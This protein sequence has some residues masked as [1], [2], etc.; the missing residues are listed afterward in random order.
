MA[1]LLLGLVGALGAPS[2]SAGAGDRAVIAWGVNDAM[3]RP[4]SGLTDVVAIAAGSDHSLA[5]KGDGTVVAFGTDYYGQTVVPAGLSGVTAIAAG[6][7]HSSA[8]KSDG[9]VVGWGY[10][11]DGENTPPSGLSDVTAISDGGYH[12][13]ARR[14]DGTVVSW[15]M[16]A[17]GE[18]QP[19]GG[20]SGVTAVAAGTHHSL[21][22]RSDGTVV[23]WGYDAYGQTDVPAG[24]SGVVAIGAGIFHSLALKSDG[25]VVAWGSNGYGQT[26]VPTGLTGVTAIT[27]GG[28]NGLALTADGA[29]VGWGRNAFGESTQPATLTE[30][31][32]ISAGLNHSLALGHHPQ[33]V[34]FT[35]DPPA[36][37]VVGDSYTPTVAG[38]GSSKPVVLSLADGS[39]GCSLSDG[40]LLFT[41]PGTCVVHADQA[42]DGTY[43]AAPTV[44]QSITVNST[45]VFT[46][47]SP[48]TSGTAGTT[49][50][51]GFTASGSPAPTYQLVDGPS[52]L[53]MDSA[54]GSVSGTPTAPGSFQYAVTATNPAG[55]VTTATFTVT[56]AAAAWQPVV[57]GF[58][59]PAI[60]SV[61]GYTLGAVGN[62]WTLDVTQP[63]TNRTVYAGTITVDRGTFSRAAGVKLEP[64]D[65]WTVDG[66]KLTFRFAH[67]GDLDGLAFTTPD[68]ANA[69]TFRLTVAGK[70]ATA[71]QVFT[72][73]N[74]TAS[75]AG[76][77]LTYRRTPGR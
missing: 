22:L 12:T 62:R 45:P 30:V 19:P 75:P 21:A 38:G 56:V 44:T 77:P 48:A 42:G 10:D 72:G 17:F 26:D 64:G 65:T 76:S 33:A 69:I 20:L 60:G 1:V 49:Y 32:A 11:L 35:S 63:T 58:T 39:T 18:T 28:Y 70:P 50:R 68:A 23:G 54:T 15:G 40:V 2:A 8:L 36:P 5:L 67:Y 46:S 74:H 16:N 55:S 24:L 53:A 27:A 7:I 25:T 57:R 52:F 29:V 37:G 61:R 6:G 3:T 14:S 41:G 71:N 9:T 73:R 47:A 31:T 66:N 13:L 59:A 51:A 43:A 34:T 4:P